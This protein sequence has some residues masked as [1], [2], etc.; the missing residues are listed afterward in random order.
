MP[1]PCR[2]E[3]VAAMPQSNALRPKGLP[4]EYGD[5]VRAFAPD[6]FRAVVAFAMAVVLGL[7][8]VA[9]FIGLILGQLPPPPLTA[10]MSKRLCAGLAIVSVLAA[11]LGS[12][13]WKHWVWVCAQGVTRLQRGEANGY[14][15]ADLSGIELTVGDTRRTD[16]DRLTLRPRVG[17]DVTIR[18]N[19]VRDFRGLT[20][21]LR[22]QCQARRLNWRETRLPTSA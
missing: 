21:V 2:R 10:S 22:E 3:Q 14:L 17:R 15:W 8:A 18:R 7:L 4:P 12:A 1:F 11:M 5:P 6:T 20:D 19:D 16:S 13:T 9:L